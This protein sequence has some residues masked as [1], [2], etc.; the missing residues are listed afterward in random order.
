MTSDSLHQFEGLVSG[1]VNS[2][3]HSQTQT[4]KN[5]A[6]YAT[7]WGKFPSN[8]AAKQ[9]FSHHEPETARH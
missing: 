4:I 2:I 7:A 6:D 3:Q 5:W 8:T 1:L 9:Q